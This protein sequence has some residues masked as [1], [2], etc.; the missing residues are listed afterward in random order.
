MLYLLWSLPVLAIAA[1]IASG[2]VSSIA[3]GILGLL[4]SIPVALISAPNHFKL[5]EAVVGAAQGVWLALFI[6][7]VIIGGL[8][9]REIVAA[10]PVADASVPIP[11][12]MRR[13]ELYNACFLVGPFAEAATG[14]GVGQVTISPTLKRIGLAPIHAVI[15]GLFSQILVPWGAMANGTIVGAELAGLSPATLG[16]HSALLTL[17]L[18][19]GWLCLFWRF[20]AVAGVPGTFPTFVA[21]VFLTLTI[22]GLLVL[23]NAKLGPEIAGMAALGPIIL[24]RFAFADRPSS[25]KWLSAIHIGLPYAILIGGLATTRAVP[26]INHFLAEAIAIRPFADGPAFYP[27][28]H[29]GC[30]LAAVGLMT[31]LATARLQSIPGAFD[32]AWKQ[33][34]TPVTAIALFL[35]LAQVM[36]VSGMANGLAGG[37]RAALGP[38]AALATP[39]SAGLFGFLTSSCNSSNGL[40]MSAQVAFARAAH[41]SVPWL[42]A[43][44]NVAA[45]ALTMFSPIRLA[46]G[47]ALV[48][49]PNIE[50]Q[51]YARA[52]LLGAMPLIILMAVA[53]GL[54]FA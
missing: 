10:A 13:R 12:A 43:V 8:F 18:L 4:I 11:T 33:G 53:A 34:K 46:V 42:A 1:L 27:L 24:L 19:L 37:L 6:G 9:F 21:E 20:A 50:R 2:R 52:W 7:A 30:W 17:P 23:A 26:R 3:A 47:S 39:L 40:L 31:A 32:R 5:R 28:L 54:A 29:P 16:V 49:K 15:F 45:A 22:A 41:L 44:Q 25:D 38:G 48:E 14:Y 35:T 36:T 51:V